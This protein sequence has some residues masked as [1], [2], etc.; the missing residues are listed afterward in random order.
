[1][2]FDKLLSFIVEGV[3]GN[4]PLETLEWGKE[5]SRL[6]MAPQVIWDVHEK[7]AP[8]P[9]PKVEASGVPTAPEGFVSQHMKV[10]TVTN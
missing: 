6:P 3:N 10:S 2:L 7:G 1:M 8:E 9:F 5:V 4:A